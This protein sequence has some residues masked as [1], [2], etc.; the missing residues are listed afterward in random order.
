M[1]V[2]D[3]CAKGDV[4]KYNDV[5]NCNASDILFNVVISNDKATFEK[6]L[7]EIKSKKK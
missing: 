5:L 4:L 1:N 3:R 7:Y 6:K 2:V